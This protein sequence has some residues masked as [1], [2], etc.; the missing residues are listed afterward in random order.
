[1]V[2]FGMTFAM[3]LLLRLDFSRILFVASGMGTLVW[4]Y[5]VQI[6]I[7]RGPPLRV[8]VVPTGEVSAL[9][10][11]DHFRIDWLERPQAPSRYD[12]LVADFRADLD[13]E[14]ESFLADCAL[15]GVPVFH[16]K[17]L[18]ESVTGRVEIEHLSENSFGSLIPFLAY[19]RLRRVIDLIAAVL[20]GILLLPFLLAVALA[21][22]IDSPGPALFRQVRIGSRGQPFRVAKFRTMTHAQLSGEALDGA[23]TKENDA[24]ITRLGRFLRRS[25]IDELPQILNIIS[26]EMSWIGPRPEAEVLSRWYETE[27]PFYRYRHIVPPGVTG[28]AQVNQGHVADLG[29]VKSKLEYDFYYIKHFSPWLDALIVAKTVHI[30]ITGYGS[31]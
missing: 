24:R 22:R 31:K 13:D 15:D 1:M 2:G 9:A 26:G 23:I 19:L 18:Q 7:E 14:W 25:R 6:M 16:V 21:I 8:G 12:L 20:V 11:I 5:L 30:V 27:L 17:Q 29:Q 28:W 10:D 4:L 3:F